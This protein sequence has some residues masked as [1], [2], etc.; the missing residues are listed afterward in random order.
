MTGT[1][2]LLYD[3]GS[4]IN[5]TPMNNVAELMLSNGGDTKMPF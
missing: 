5:I 1:Y 2:N 4:N 3:M